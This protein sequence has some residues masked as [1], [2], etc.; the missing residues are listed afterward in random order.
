[1]GEGTLAWREGDGARCQEAS[2]TTDPV[3]RL[4]RRLQQNPPRD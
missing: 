2:G 4:Y 3:L 1:M